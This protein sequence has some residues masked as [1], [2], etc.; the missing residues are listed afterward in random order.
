MVFIFLSFSFNFFYFHP[1]NQFMWNNKLNVNETMRSSV[2]KSWSFKLSCG[3]QGSFHICWLIHSNFWDMGF[4]FEMTDYFISGVVGLLYEIFCYFSMWSS[5]AINMLI[6][7][8][9]FHFQ[10][11]IIGK[12]KFTKSFFFHAKLLRATH[13]THTHTIWPMRCVCMEF[14]MIYCYFTEIQ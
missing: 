11:R 12:W 9:S 1:L 13:N 4:N 2:L 14:Q 8:P 3:C 6:K 10:F 5:C 7:M